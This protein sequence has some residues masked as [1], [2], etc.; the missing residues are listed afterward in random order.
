MY[1]F[2]SNRQALAHARGSVE[3]ASRA[4]TV[5]ERFPQIWALAASLLVL[6]G[7]LLTPRLDS[8]VQ[9]EETQE[10]AE[11]QS[12]GCIS[13]HGMTEARTMHPTG[14]VRIGCADCHGGHPDVQK[15]V[16]TAAGSKAYD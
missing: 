5:R 6:S 15:P 9:L 13:C 10:E 16:G 8:Q 12:T 14:T 2:S 3:S 4:A 1:D 11:R 7:V